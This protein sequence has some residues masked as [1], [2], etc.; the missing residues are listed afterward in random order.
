[1]K[2]SAKTPSQLK[3]NQIERISTGSDELNSL[4][5]GGFPKDSLILLAG[6]PGTGKTLLAS[7]YLW[8]GL[9]RGS[10]CIY[11]S[12]AEGRKDFMNN[13][14]RFGL[15][16]DAF[17]RKRKFKF[18]ELAAV[19]EV[20]L[21][22]ILQLIPE[23]IHS[24]KA[25]R[26]VIDSISAMAQAFKERI[27]TRIIIHTILGKIAKATGVTTI[28]ISEVP[29][30]T[31]RIGEGIE[32]FVSDGIIH[33]RA[34]QERGQM[35]RRL[36]VSKMRGTRI[37]PRPYLYDIEERGITLYIHP[38]ITH[39]KK[40]TGDRLKIGVEGLDEMAVGGLYRG[41]TTLISGASGTGKTILSLRFITQGASEGEK[42]LFISFEE[43]ASQLR[44]TAASFGWNLQDYEY[45]NL[46][47][48]QS[49]DSN[50][51][52]AESTLWEIAKIIEEFGPKRIVVDSLSSLEHMMDE[53]AFT[54]FTA[55]LTSV[56]K[57]NQ[58]TSIFTS[59]TTALIG[60]HTITEAR[61]STL[62]D[63]IIMLRYIE[64]ESEI[65][66][67]LNI[68]KLRGSAHDKDIREFQI[69]DGGIDVKTKFRDLENL[70][71]GTP[72]RFNPFA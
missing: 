49:F 41:S 8:D 38:R 24:M 4:I 52:T 67:S 55:R 59:A 56:L 45:K 16:F 70:L 26:L 34:G 57:S 19:K 18:L 44:R 12:F 39:Q 23:Q 1:M 42:G 63:N 51:T 29:M 9:L 3:K 66:R 68:L 6:N 21:E 15:D 71:S 53:L 31:E 43:P 5:E 22:S 69:G 61:V 58:I 40:P 35:R 37:N 36:M 7:Y 62:L 33:L 54:E 20:G 30:G 47:K 13:L 64:L 11:V 2:N 60:G 27:D 14:G 10:N 65:K 72:R 28:L 17:E 50:D 32:E 48:I 46:V 25:E